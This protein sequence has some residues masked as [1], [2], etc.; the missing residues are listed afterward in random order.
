[1]ITKAI[2]WLMAEENPVKRVKLF[3]ENNQ[4]VRYLHEEELNRLLKNSSPSL[5]AIVL[6]AVNTGM[7]KGEIQNLK[8]A[9]VNF[10]EGYIAIREAK[11]GG[12][13]YVPLNQTVKD[14][15]LTIKKHP[16][17]P[18]VFCAKSGQ[19]YNFRKSFETAITNSGIFDFRFHDLRH[20]FASRLAMRGVDL[21]TIR[22]LMGHKSLDM[23]L[24]YSH[25]SK[26]HKAR[27][28]SILD[29]P[30]PKVSPSTSLTNDQESLEFVTPLKLAS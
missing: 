23:T 20:T 3:K 24:R 22:E 1:M 15:L 12:G 9:D 10:Q 14:I 6:F 8:W 28:V 2:D 21:N 29:E 7:R 5:H 11:N 4:R 25:L 13:R 16:E 18:Y 17:S 19:P 30:V 27:A 26:D